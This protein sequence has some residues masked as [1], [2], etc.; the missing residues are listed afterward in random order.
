[1]PAWSSL[2][3][4]VC[5][6]LIASAC[7][8]NAPALVA[9]HTPL[10]VAANESLQDLVIPADEK[11][12]VAL[13]SH[14]RKLNAYEIRCLARD[15]TVLGTRSLTWGNWDAAAVGPGDDDV[16]LMQSQ[17]A[18][19]VRTPD[20]R[21]SDR[22]PGLGRA[23]SDLNRFGIV[24]LD[25]A[26]TREWISYGF[27]VAKITRTPQWTARTY[28]VEA[29]ETQGAAKIPGTSHVALIAR[30]HQF[31]VIDVDSGAT[32]RTEKLPCRKVAFSVVANG[33]SAWVA[34]M[35]GDGSFLEVPLAGDR[36]VVVRSTGATGATHLAL[37]HDGRT[38]VVAANAAGPEAVDHLAWVV[39]YDVSDGLR[40]I[41]RTSIEG[42]AGGLAVFNDGTVVVGGGAAMARIIRF[43]PP[44]K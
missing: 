23:V 12:V 33:R 9:T 31:M 30:P 34:T 6:G 24:A 38:L 21:E 29:D 17:V 14:D 10:Q 22:S 43:A 44:A 18:C 41:G 36:S 37:S 13:V 16:L 1:M 8:A 20:F 19:V 40:E 4:L 39:L 26:S 28:T 32:L 5:V 11:S 7:A 35:D 3:A 42:G 25:R 27:N 15:G 2:L